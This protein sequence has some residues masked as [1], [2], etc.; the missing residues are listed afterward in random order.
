MA[1]FEFVTQIQSPH[2]VVE[3]ARS[4]IDS[5]L[6]EELT[7]GSIAKSVGVSVQDLKD[8]YKCSTPMT[9]ERD[10]KKIRLSSLYESIKRNPLMDLKEHAAMVGL[11]C[12][13]ELNS[14]FEDEFWISLED[15]QRNC[16]TFKWCP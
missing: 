13:S 7:P 14:D 10:I 15:H 16:M 6:Q 2:Q 1:S 8:C 5:H 12:D 3:A 11:S 9:V 4:F